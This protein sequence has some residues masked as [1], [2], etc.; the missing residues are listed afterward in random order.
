MAGLA[1]LLLRFP[2]LCWNIPSRLQISLTPYSSCGI[3]YF[4]RYNST[5]VAKVSHCRECTKICNTSLLIVKT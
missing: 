5:N 1:K 2:R 4:D 3:L